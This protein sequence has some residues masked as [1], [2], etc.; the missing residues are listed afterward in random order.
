MT[1]TT[2]KEKSMK[3]ES[4]VI[5]EAS[6]RQHQNQGRPN[7]T[8]NPPNN[9]PQHQT[10]QKGGCT[11]LFKEQMHI[12]V[13]FVQKGACIC[14]FWPKTCMYTRLLAKNPCMYATVGQ[15]PMYTEKTVVKSRPRVK[16]IKGSV[17]G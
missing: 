4:L 13:T 14:G 7:H 3:R 6:N 2:L 9:F 12:Y 8:H 5:K 15:K 1:K 17:N 10:H 11:R 16:P